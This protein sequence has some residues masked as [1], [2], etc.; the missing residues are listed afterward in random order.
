MRGVR[1]HRGPAAAVTP[2]RDGRSLGQY[3]DD[4]LDEGIPIDVIAMVI[5]EHWRRDK[6]VP[7]QQTTEQE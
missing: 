6:R 5:E 1:V 7:A 4:L 2:Y 3:V